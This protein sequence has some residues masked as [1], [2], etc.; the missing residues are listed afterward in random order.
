MDWSIHK[1]N[2]EVQISNFVN[3]INAN[4]SLL[5]ADYI[6]LDYIII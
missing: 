3:V 5:F 1:H 6:N 4:K 2:N